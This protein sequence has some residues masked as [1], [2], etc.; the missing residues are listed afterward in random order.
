M[1]ILS[2]LLTLDLSCGVPFKYLSK[3]QEGIL[4]N[5]LARIIYAIHIFVA[6]NSVFK[7]FHDITIVAF[8]DAMHQSSN[9]RSTL[10]APS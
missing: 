3:E 2:A 10:S 1:L 7:F 9:V 4:L 8:G 6:I 5:Y